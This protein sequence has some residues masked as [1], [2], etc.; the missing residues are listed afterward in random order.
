MARTTQKR[1]LSLEGLIF[2]SSSGSIWPPLP[3]TPFPCVLPLSYEIGQSIH[4]AR[5]GGGDFEMQKNLITFIKRG[6]RV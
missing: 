1:A 6:L 5:G 2:H 3:L 4:H